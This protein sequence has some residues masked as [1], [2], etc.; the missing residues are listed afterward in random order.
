LPL[1]GLGIRDLRF[2]GDDLLVLAGPTMDHDG[3]GALFRWRSPIGADDDMVHVP[4]DVERIMDLSCARGADQAE[5]V[6]FVDVG[7]KRRLLVVHD[8]PPATRLGNGGE[9]LVVDLFDLER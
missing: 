3:T 6:A 1:S 5:G 2:E 8:S 7:T 9:S 4:Q